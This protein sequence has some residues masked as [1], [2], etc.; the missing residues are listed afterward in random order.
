MEYRRKLTA[1]L[2][3]A[4]TGT[5]VLVAPAAQAGETGR[6]NTA[7]G[8]GALA[9]YGIVKK[10]PV[11]AGL[12]GGGAIYSYMRSRESARRE[13]ERRRAE[14]RARARARSRSR[15]AG[16]RRVASFS[17]ASCA[18]PSDKHGQHE[19]HDRDD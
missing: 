8:L 4:A 5:A 12:A 17:R 3:A 11:V 18:R 9:V 13:R 6:R 14:A 19:K 1:V 16:H 7:I 10:Q 2:L 15:G